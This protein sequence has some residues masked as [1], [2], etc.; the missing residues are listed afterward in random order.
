MY[1]SSIVM[2]ILFIAAGAKWFFS[3]FSWLEEPVP[4]EKRE[5]NRRLNGTVS[6]LG[7]A[8]MLS[9][10]LF[11]NLWLCGGLLVI[12]CVGYFWLRRKYKIQ[13]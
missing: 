6:V 10:P 5:I 8:I 13:Y 3:G 9:Y 4:L 12:V 11:E 7:G 1:I 2:G